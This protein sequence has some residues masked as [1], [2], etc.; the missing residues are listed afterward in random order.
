MEDSSFSASAIKVVDN[1]GYK[2]T[3]LPDYVLLG[4]VDDYLDRSAD[5]RDDAAE[6]FYP[7]EK[8]IAQ[9]FVRYALALEPSIPAGA[10]PILRT[11][12][13]GHI[14]V[15]SKLI[16]ARVE[17][18]YEAPMP[19]T[20]WPGRTSMKLPK[21][22]FPPITSR[23]YRPAEVDPRFSY[24]YGAYL[25]YGNDEPFQYCLANSSGRVELIKQFLVDLDATSVSHSFTVKTLPT[26]NDIA[27]EPDAILAALLR[28]AL[29]ER[30][31]A[32]KGAAT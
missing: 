14:E 5:R 13:A 29:D 10:M 19:G 25:R 4:M 3:L 23:Q 7:N 9:L 22:A 18:F 27:F 17:A 15:T 1:T 6:H 26:K 32:Q 30:S 28:Q 2:P 12:S 8:A 21:S 16:K 20:P 31:A 11:A 24:L